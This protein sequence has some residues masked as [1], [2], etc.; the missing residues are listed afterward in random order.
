[1]VWL[2]MY[3]GSKD[4][5]LVNKH[6][7]N[8]NIKMYMEHRQGCIYCNF[9]LSLYKL[10]KNLISSRILKENTILSVTL[11]VV[12]YFNFGKMGK[13]AC[14]YNITTI[15]NYY[16]KQ[17]NAINAW[18]SMTKSVYNLVLSINIILNVAHLDLNN[19]II[20]Q[21]KEWMYPWSLLEW[22]LE[23]PYVLIQQYFCTSQNSKSFKDSCW[24]LSVL[25]FRT[26]V[27]I[28]YCGLEIARTVRY[29][30]NK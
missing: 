7:I 11:Y 30:H 27:L 17:Q 21:N 18:T 14:I 12:A 9:D 23:I 3:K 28:I 1:M 24:F 15:K 20:W 5:L 22:T 19:R 29:I 2:Y 8:I 10:Q 16:W 25:A 13:N 26:F 4:W 6:K